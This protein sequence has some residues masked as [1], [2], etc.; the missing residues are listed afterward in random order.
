MKKIIVPIDF[1]EENPDSLISYDWILSEIEKYQI[2]AKVYLIDAC[3][4]GS[5]I[6]TKS[7][8]DYNNALPHYLETLEDKTQDNFYAVSNLVEAYFLAEDFNK[9]IEYAEKIK[10]HSKFKKS[11]TQFIYGLALEKFENFDEAEANLKQIDRAY[12]FYEE[13]LIL[14]KFLMSR[15][16]TDGA[17]AILTEIQK[18]SEYMTK[19]N[20]RLY[21]STILE[22]EKLLL[23]HQV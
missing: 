7:I 1:S 20:R 4:A 6:D 12:S 21:K 17:K 23:E 11:R 10:D 13:R 14:A 9:A 8:K 19:P 2:G 5:I 3:Y 15:G 18:E 16:K 22:V